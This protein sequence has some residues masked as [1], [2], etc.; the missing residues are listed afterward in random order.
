MTTVYVDKRAGLVL[1]DSRVSWTEKRMFLGLFPLKDK[2]HCGLAGQ[3]SMYIHDRLFCAAGSVPSINKVL[4]YLVC[5]SVVKAD[6][7][8]NCHCMLISKNYVIHLITYNGKFS[9]SVEFIGNDYT[10]IIGS[11]APY[12]IDAKM[13]DDQETLVDKIFKTFQ[14]VKNHDIYSDDNIQIHRF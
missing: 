1:T 12:M 2:F 11:G 9:K 10:Y 14:N 8:S 6:Y 5:G 3:K 4:N 13:H 7:N